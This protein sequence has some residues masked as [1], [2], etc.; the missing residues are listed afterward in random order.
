MNKLN[1]TEFS[2]LN[3]VGFTF[4]QNNIAKKT[5]TDMILRV[6]EPCDSQVVNYL[7]IHSHFIYDLCIYDFAYTS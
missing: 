2:N 6:M 1:L 5:K 4:F 3:F 7:S